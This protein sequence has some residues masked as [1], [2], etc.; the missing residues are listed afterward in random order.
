MTVLAKRVVE[1]PARNGPCHHALGSA[2]RSMAR[3]KIEMT[4]I[5]LIK[6]RAP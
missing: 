1:E 5:N 6:V 4:G 3:R 2:E